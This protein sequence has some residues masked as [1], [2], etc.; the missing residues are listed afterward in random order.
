MINSCY[1]IL[2]S[3]LRQKKERI[4]IS[5]YINSHVYIDTPYISDWLF[6]SLKYKIQNVGK[7][8]SMVESS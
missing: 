7:N 3:N 8:V 1:S 2:F 5:R 6:M 4:I